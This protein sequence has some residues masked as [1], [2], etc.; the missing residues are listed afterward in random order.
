MAQKRTLGKWRRPKPLPD[1]GIHSLTLRNSKASK[2]CLAKASGRRLNAFLGLSF[3]RTILFLVILFHNTVS[4][5]YDSLCITTLAL[6]ASNDTVVEPRV[7][8]FKGSEARG[9]YGLSWLLRRQIGDYNS[10]FS[11]LFAVAFSPSFHN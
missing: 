11:S 1:S 5:G 8:V 9:P 2:H 7:Q 4:V 6:D 10:C 3:N